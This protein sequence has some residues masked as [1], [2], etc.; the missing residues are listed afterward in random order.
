[1]NKVKALV[2]AIKA[3]KKGA[4]VKAVS[5]AIGIAGVTLLAKLIKS[6][7]EMEVGEFLEE[8][9]VETEVTDSE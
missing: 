6:G 9:E 2:E 8:I 4:A 7:A 1:M 5:V 3:D